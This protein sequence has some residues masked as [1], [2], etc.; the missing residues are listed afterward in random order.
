M[1]M[2]GNKKMPPPPPPRV[3]CSGARN[4]GMPCERFVAEG[5]THCFL[6]DRISDLDAPPMSR[7]QLYLSLLYLAA[8][9]VES[10]A[11]I[12]SSCPNDAVKLDAIA[13]YGRWVGLG[14]GP[15]PLLTVASESRS[16]NLT[17]LTPAELVARATEVIERLKERTDQE[18]S[19]GI[20]DPAG[21]AAITTPE[22]STRA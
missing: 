3:R 16:V 2:F 22:D 13:L 4:D 5:E 21:S 8:P 7:R 6:H 18:G 17:D 10:L 19:A 15:H 11:R 1:A 12:I 14:V 20:A 9:A